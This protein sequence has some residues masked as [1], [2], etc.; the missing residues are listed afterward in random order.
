VALGMRI[1]ASPGE[2][3]HPWTPPPRYG[4]VAARRGRDPEPIRAAPAE[5]AARIAG[6]S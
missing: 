1:S 4:T 2:K 3:P 5:A 6:L